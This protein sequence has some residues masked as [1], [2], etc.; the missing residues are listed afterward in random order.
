M[1]ILPLQIKYEHN[2]LVNNPPFITNHPVHE[3]LLFYKNEFNNN[4][5]DLFK[6]EYAKDKKDNS[7]ISVC[8]A[9]AILASTAAGVFVYKRI[10]NGIK[11][12]K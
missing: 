10:I 7:F 3:K 1:E 8:L 11:K 12:V 6:S 2:N 4:E 5:R 9:G